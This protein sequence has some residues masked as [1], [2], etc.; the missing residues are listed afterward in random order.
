VSVLSAHQG[1]AGGPQQRGEAS[2]I[3]GVKRDTCSGIGLAAEINGQ[4]GFFNDR[5]MGV[6]A[7]SKRP[8]K[9]RWGVRG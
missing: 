6:C 9:R 5:V 7:P 1:G 4:M 2:L 3:N 8:L